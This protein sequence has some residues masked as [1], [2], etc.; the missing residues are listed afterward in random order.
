M[1]WHGLRILQAHERVKRHNIRDLHE[2]IRTTKNAGS[3]AERTDIGGYVIKVVV[4]GL[5]SAGNIVTIYD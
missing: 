2:A 4:S 5:S 1:F 3:D